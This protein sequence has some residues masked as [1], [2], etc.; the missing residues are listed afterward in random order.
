VPDASLCGEPDLNDAGCELFDTAGD[1]N[2]YRCTVRC[3]SYDDCPD[4]EYACDTGSPRVC[5]F[6]PMVPEE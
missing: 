5:S 6:T 2:I 4:G 1:D 3:G